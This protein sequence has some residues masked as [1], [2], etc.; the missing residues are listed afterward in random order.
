MFDGA[1]AVPAEPACERDIIRMDI[2]GLA[3]VCNLVPAAAYADYILPWVAFPAHRKR[4]TRCLAPNGNLH[5][6]STLQQ[7]VPSATWVAVELPVR[8]LAAD[9]A[10]L[11]VYDTLYQ[12]SCYSVTHNRGTL[13][14]VVITAPP[15]TDAAGKANLRLPW[16]EI[17]P[18]S[19]GRTI[20]I[21]S[22]AGKCK[23]GE[24]LEKDMK[25]KPPV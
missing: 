10:L 17:L 25:L 6:S 4:W 11:A 22:Y 20:D 1:M 12:L 19:S 14:E 7:P 3:I 9:V 21:A 2:A 24:F 18:A 8:V 16:P 13:G 23:R 15:G 5:C